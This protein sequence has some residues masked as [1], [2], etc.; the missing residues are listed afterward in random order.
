LQLRHKVENRSHY[1]EIMQK[2]R[3]EYENGDISFEE[4]DESIRVR[5]WS[6]ALSGRYRSNVSITL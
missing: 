5:C 1:T 3:I 6:S 2:T 4:I